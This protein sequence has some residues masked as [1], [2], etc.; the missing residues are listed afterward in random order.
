M[1]GRL[2][3]LRWKLARP[4]SELDDPPDDYEVRGRDLMTGI[5]KVIKISYTEI[6]FALDKSISKIEEAIIRTL[7]NSP[8]NF[9]PIFTSKA[10]M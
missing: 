9:P 7:E 3:R 6:S 5:P 2:K 8:P 10:F 1:N 4:L